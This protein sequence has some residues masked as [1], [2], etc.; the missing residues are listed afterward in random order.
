MFTYVN[1]SRDLIEIG[2]QDSPHATGP[3][4]PGAPLTKADFSRRSSRGQEA[5][6]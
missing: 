3:D 4:H 5:T 2:Y 1:H 6:S